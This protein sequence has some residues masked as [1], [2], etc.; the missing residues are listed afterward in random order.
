MSVRTIGIEGYITDE[1]ALRKSF[2]DLTRRFQVKII[3]R[4]TVSRGGVFK[5]IGDGGEHHKIG[6]PQGHAGV[7]FAQ[8][9]VGRKPENARQGMY[10]AADIATVQYEQ[11]KNQVPGAQ[12]CFS[13]HAADGGGLSVAAR[14][15]KHHG[16]AVK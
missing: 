3:G 11:G 7:D 13:D 2:F 12:V 5:R 1:A 10:L 14:T 9:V 16:M 6:Q 8:Q 4:I 15:T